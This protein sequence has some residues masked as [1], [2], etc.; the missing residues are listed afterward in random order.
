MLYAEAVFR[1][2]ALLTPSSL[3]ADLLCAWHAQGEGVKMKTSMGR[4]KFYSDSIPATPPFELGLEGWVGSVTWGWQ[5]G[6]ALW[7]WSHGS[8]SWETRAYRT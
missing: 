4:W 5:A 2:R 7:I 6:G 1:R 3:T 8:Q